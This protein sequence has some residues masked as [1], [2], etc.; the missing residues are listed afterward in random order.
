MP[1]WTAVDGKTNDPKRVSRFKVEI[2]AL[3][4]GGIVWYAKSFTKPS[5]TISTTKHKYLNHT[6]NYPGSVEWGDVTLEL[7]DPTDPIDAAGSLAQLLE[8][9]GYQI[10]DKPSSLD[11]GAQSVQLFTISKRKANSTLGVITVSHLDDEGQEIE[12]WE[13]KQAFV[14]K[15]E[16]GSLK[17]DG[18]ELNVLKLTIKYDWAT[19][20]IN[21][22]LL[23]EASPD[24]AVKGDKTGTF[25]SKGATGRATLA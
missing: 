10:P 20:T 17:Y 16:W 6:F 5:A 1:F 22:N 21:N 13:L 18:D 11:A 15:F 8:G 25:F 12:T 2:A 24:S 14:T 7:I 3:N 19:C 9:M 4:E 23:T